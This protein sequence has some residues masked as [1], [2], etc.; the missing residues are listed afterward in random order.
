MLDTETIPTVEI[1]K[2]SL[3]RKDGKINGI[4]MAHL[5]NDY[6]E[7]VSPEYQATISVS[8]G[9][10]IIYQLIYPIKFDIVRARPRYICFTDSR[11]KVLAYIDYGESLSNNE[12][13]E[14]HAPL[15]LMIGMVS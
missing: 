8:I 7:A 6:C 11:K 3:L 4:L 14:L 12:T 15:N 10:L 5:T 13:Y 9:K 2:C 1:P